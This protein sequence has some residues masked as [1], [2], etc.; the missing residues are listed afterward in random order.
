MVALNDASKVN[1][2]KDMISGVK[3]QPEILVGVEGAEQVARY[4]FSTYFT[5]LLFIR[6]YQLTNYMSTFCTAR[7]H[8]LSSME[9]SVHHCKS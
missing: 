8:T 1:E 5:H 4:F 9:S 3:P 7:T 6:Y 2:L